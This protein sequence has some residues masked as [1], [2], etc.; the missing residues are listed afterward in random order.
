IF[1]LGTSHTGKSPF[2][3]RVAEAL[4]IPCYGASAW[5]RERWP[6]PVPPPD[7]SDAER[8]A[9]VDAITRFAIAQL[10]RGPAISIAHLRRHADLDRPCVIE[11]M[12]NPYDFVACFDPRRDRVVHLRYAHAA[13]ATAFEHGLDV[14]RAYLAWLAAVGLL[15]AGC[16]TDA[17]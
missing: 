7:A 14:I 1:V 2:A 8:A 12:R 10:R 16:V 6:D 9:F 15:D 4:A 5:V 11:G 17:R 13:P 3:R